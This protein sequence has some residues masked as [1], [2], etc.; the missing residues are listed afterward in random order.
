MQINEVT[1][2]IYKNTEF[3]NVEQIIDN[4]DGSVSWRRVP[5]NVYESLDRDGG[6]NVSRGSTGVEIR[7]K[8]NSDKVTLRMA[9]REGSGLFHVYR[10]G[11]QGGYADH[12]VHKTVT[13]TVEDFVIERS[14]SPEKLRVLTEKSGT[15]WNCDVV[16]IIFDRGGFKI[17]DIIGDIEPPAPED[18]PSK[19]LMCYGSS[20][21]HGSN[22]LDM[23][24][25]WPALVAHNIGYDIKNKGMAGSCCME[26]AYAEY[27]AAEGMK[28]HWHALTLE[29]GINVLDWNE[30]TFRER[31][32]NII[33]TVAE[34]NPTKP[35]F[36]ISPFYH[37]GEY[38]DEND[39][40]PLWRSIISE[41]TS[42]FAYPNVTYINGLD[43]LGDM[44]L[45]SADFVHP[46][47]YGVAQIAER[48][49]PII[50]QHIN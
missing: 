30:D 24:H 3:H 27:I 42:N 10:G 4:G 32:T 44:S 6:R 17:F 15:E 38:F 26:P 28:N 23:S 45:I 1:D 46:N 37:C 2:M 35:I 13:E 14:S 43:L 18:C 33:K 20:I 7:F 39:H 9:V 25:S 34:S 11:I 19:T 49:T 22:S 50:K 47:I 48:L 31:V 36:V 12:E 40:A 29:L 41:I 8:M 21:T 16:R 5:E